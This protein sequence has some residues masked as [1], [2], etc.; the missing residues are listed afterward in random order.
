MTG[1]PTHSVTSDDI[2]SIPDL[3]TADGKTNEDQQLKDKERALAQSFEHSGSLPI[4]TGASH[5]GGQQNQ[6]GG[7]ALSQSEALISKNLHLT[8]IKTLADQFGGRVVDV[9]ENSVIVELTAKT[10][11]VEAFLAL[12]RQFGVLE[13]A[14]SGGCLR[15][16]GR[17]EDGNERWIAYR[18]WLICGH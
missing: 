7:H 10:S 6:Q 9:A 4:G 15:R 17:D 8:A 1:G 5:G 12:M 2:P 13:A 11:R 3:V 18:C 16:S 14:R